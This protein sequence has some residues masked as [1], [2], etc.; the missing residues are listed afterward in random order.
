MQ[1]LGYLNPPNKGEVMQQRSSDAAFST[2]RADIN[3][4]SPNREV[5]THHRHEMKAALKC[6]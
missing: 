5:Y 4:D 6:G 2:P 3:E 1:W